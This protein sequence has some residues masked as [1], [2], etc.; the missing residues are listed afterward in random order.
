[1][2]A[3]CDAWRYTE[4]LQIP[5]VVFGGGSITSSHAKNEHISF[6]DL[7]KAATSLILF[8]DKWSGLK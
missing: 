2:N 5:A 3:A 1:M 8:I 4:Q 7:Q 6:A